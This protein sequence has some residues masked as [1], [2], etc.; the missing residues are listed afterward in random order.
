MGLDMYL[1]AKQ[2]TSKYFQEENNQKIIDVLPDVKNN[3]A[4][5]IGFIEISFEIGYW[6]KANQ[7]H[8]WFVKNVQN[9]TDDCSTYDVSVRQLKDLK[10]RC[11]QVLA[12]RDLA[13]EI[14]PTVS[15]FFFGDTVYDNW[16]FQDIE[17]TIKIIDKCLSLQGD[18]GF[19]YRSSW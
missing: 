3:I 2:Y 12:N 10:L 17:D 14:L 4:D 9:G 8:N 7:I 6:R 5:N 18:W 11:E 16:Y 13:C 15:G 19:S 1:Y